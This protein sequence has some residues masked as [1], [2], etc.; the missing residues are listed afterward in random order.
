MSTFLANRCS[1]DRHRPRQ[2]N[3]RHT[4]SGLE[5][6]SLPVCMLMRKLPLPK[7]PVIDE[8]CELYKHLALCVCS[9]WYAYINTTWPPILLL[10]LL[11]LWLIALITIFAC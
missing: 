6:C 5:L 3:D 10:L 4:C 11:L 8:K 7:L 9:V 2:S 1:T